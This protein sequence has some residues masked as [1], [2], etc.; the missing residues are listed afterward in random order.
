MTKKGCKKTKK[1]KQR[2]GFKKRKKKREKKK[3]RGGK[4]DENAH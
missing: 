1:N 2:P 3:K 4:W